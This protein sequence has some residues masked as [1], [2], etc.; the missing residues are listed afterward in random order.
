MVLCREEEEDWLFAVLDFEDRALVDVIL[1]GIMLGIFHDHPAIRASWPSLLFHMAIERIIEG[2]EHSFDDK[3][4]H[5]FR[6]FW[7]V[8]GV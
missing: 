3:T 8:V 7:T 5:I 4:V 1:M 2:G 6:A